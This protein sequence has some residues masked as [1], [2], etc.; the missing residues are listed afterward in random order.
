[1]HIAGSESAVNEFIRAMEWNEE[2]SAHGVGRVFSCDT[3]EIGGNCD[4]YAIG[5]S[6]DCAWSILS[7]MR[8][9]DNPNNIEKLSERLGL[10][11]EAFSAEYGI[12]FEEHLCIDNGEVTV[13]ECVD[14]YEVCVEDID[15][16][17]FDRDDFKKAGI[18][19]DNCMDFADDGWIKVG[20][21]N[22]YW[23]FDFV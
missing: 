22:G 12:G 23:S 8:V 19:K 4:E 9:A 15:D 2:Y 21:F 18:T 16:E 20:G 10:R 6:G 13:D 7:S 5:C 17:I 1:M 14:A 11:I 3:F